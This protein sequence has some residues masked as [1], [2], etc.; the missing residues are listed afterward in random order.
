[1]PLVQPSLHRRL[2]LATLALL[3]VFLGLTG[4]LLGNAQQQGLEVEIR[5]RLL[6]HVYAL[7]AEA[8]ED[9]Q[10]ILSLPEQPADPRLSQIDSGLQAELADAQGK[11]LWRSGSLLGIETPPM[12]VLAAGE[13]RFGRDTHAY[14]LLF[15]LEW[16]TLEG[17]QHPYV[18]RIGLQAGQVEQQLQQFRAR[19]WLGLLLLGL[20]LLVLQGLLL[21]WGLAPLRRIAQGVS[22][23]EAGRAGQISG[24]YPAELQPLADNLNSLMAHNKAQQERYRTNLDDLAHSIKTPLALLQ[25]AL[26][27]TEP[28]ALR[29]AALQALPHID[30]LLRGRLR[31]AGAS[32]FAGLGQRSALR[33]LA[34]RLL[35]TLA[36]VY[37]ERRLDMENRIDAGLAIPVSENDLL[38]ML[39]NLLDNACKHAHSRLLIAAEQQLSGW[40]IRVEDDGPGIAAAQREQVQRR[41]KRLDEQYPGQGIGLAAANNLAGLYQGRL[42]IGSSEALGG[43][44]VRLFLADNNY[45]KKLDHFSRD[46]LD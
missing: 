22:E 10:G 13:Q 20:I 15:G 38:E 41:G 21:R 33:P 44:C 46:L 17:A 12:P 40:L 1:M 42:E 28:E 18:L 8:R 37:A 32:G 36:K 14:R 26:D 6:G 35:A 29:Q 11:I 2:S 39:G 45:Q 25:G 16:E 7:L 23:I 34:Q 43:A 5:N 3:L 27:S 4:W 19:L 9:D 30:V 24:S 31:Q